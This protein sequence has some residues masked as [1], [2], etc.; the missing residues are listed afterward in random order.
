MRDQTMPRVT[1]WTLSLQREVFRNS[2]VELR[3]LGTRGMKL[4]VQRQVNTTSAFDNGA[5]ALPTP[6]ASMVSLIK[7]VF[8]TSMA[9]PPVD[10]RSTC[11]EPIIIAA[12][13]SPPRSPARGGPPGGPRRAAGRGGRAR[14]AGG[15]RPV[16]P[17]IGGLAGGETEGNER[18]GD[19]GRTRYHR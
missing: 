9:A 16:A 4:P 10:S 2:S 14:A 17:R 5:Q 12:G 11:F 6:S 3:Y 13:S 8:R 1:T 7:T 19:E 18:P 15:D